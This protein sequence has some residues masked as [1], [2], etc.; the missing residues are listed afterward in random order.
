MMF[1]CCAALATQDAMIIGADF[2]ESHTK[3]A[4]L[5]A[6]GSVPIGIGDNCVIT[7]AIIDKNAAIGKVRGCRFSSMASQPSH[8]QCAGCG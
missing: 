5:L 7:N 3:R 2:Y 4:R 8:C 6:S 1:L